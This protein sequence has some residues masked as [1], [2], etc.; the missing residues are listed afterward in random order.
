MRRS[1]SPRNSTLAPSPSHVF[2]RGL[3]AHGL[4]ATIGA[5]GVATTR[6]SARA[7]ATTTVTDYAVCRITDAAARRNWSGVCQAPGGD[8]AVS[9]DVSRNGRQA[10]VLDIPGKNC[11]AR[12]DD[13]IYGGVSIVVDSS[14]SVVTTDPQH[15]RIDAAT[16]TLELVESDAAEHPLPSSDADFPR[17]GV[18][19]YGG[20]G[21]TETGW[22]ADGL[23][24]SYNE[25]Y[26]ADGDGL[27]PTFDAAGALARWTQK[28][29]AGQLLSICEYLRPVIATDGTR[30][31]RHASF[32]DF[33]GRGDGKDKGPRGGTD[34][35]HFS[36]AIGQTN[37]LGGSAARARNAI[38]I[39]DGLPNIPK[40]VDA[41]T[42]RNTSY[43]KGEK[44]VAIKGKDG[45][46]REVCMYRQAQMAADRANGYLET[47][48][49]K[50]A[51]INVYN[52]LFAPQ[53]KVY[54]DVDVKG[55]INPPDFLIENSARTG[56]GKVKFTWA[57]NKAELTTFV[58][59]TLERRFN[60]HS[61]QRVLVKV[62]T[63]PEYQA[64]SPADTSESD[65]VF[66]IKFVNLQ[67]G[68]NS[69]KVTYVYSDQ[70]VER[71]YAINVAGNSG[72]VTTPFACTAGPAGKTIDGD[73]PDDLSPAGDGVLPPT[74][75]GGYQRVYRNAD[76][77]NDYDRDRLNPSSGGATGVPAA[78]PTPDDEDPR[79]LRLQ[80]GTGNCG[81]VGGVGGGVGASSDAGQGTNAGAALALLAAPVLLALAR[82][83]VRS[84]TRRR[85]AG[86]PRA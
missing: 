61:L 52:V 73:E 79:K 44:I 48:A 12:S 4:L 66:S 82:V 34:L 29:A 53:D 8:S 84:R 2:L 18:V 47:N 75:S 38:V 13:G 3:G 69:V 54:F 62:N 31:E 30:M 32:L 67:D 57:T 70:A 20:R 45:T 65:K 6:T 51:G 17:V 60:K 41:A 74:T 50:F 26:C 71:T 83:R 19:S 72:T 10:V 14:R 77:E 24:R 49:A 23:N 21:G 40:Y 15:E 76:A 46:T 81:V 39:T 27:S 59:E 63:D 58:R 16:E 80:G 1:P 78:T 68:A 25:K 64:V 43:L 9:I 33:T 35:S 55:R 36:E 22:E 42:C 86:G 85:A 7:Q 5:L 28:N 37:M 56:N 11:R